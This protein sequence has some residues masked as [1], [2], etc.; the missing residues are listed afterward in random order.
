[1]RFPTMWHF[2]SVDSG[3]LVQPLFK[4][5]LIERI[6]ILL[7]KNDIRDWYQSRKAC[8]NKIIPDQTFPR[9]AV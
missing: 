3:E 2:A 6:S 7:E 1:M 8:A 5:S 4:L 9:G